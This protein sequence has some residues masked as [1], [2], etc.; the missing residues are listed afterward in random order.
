MRQARA[1]AACPFTGVFST[2]EDEDRQIAEM[3]QA[4]VTFE[5]SFVSIRES[6][7]FYLLLAFRLS[8]VVSLLLGYHV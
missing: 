2:R 6:A 3:R 4:W 5:F 8:G 1:Y 7:E